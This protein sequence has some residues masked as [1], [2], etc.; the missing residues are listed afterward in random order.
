MGGLLEPPLARPLSLR[1][2]TRDELLGLLAL[3]ADVRD[4]PARYAQTRAGRTL[5]TIFEKPSLRTQVSFQ[6]AAYQLGAKVIDLVPRK[7]VCTSGNRSKT[8]RERST[9]WWTG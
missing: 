8:W 1:E 4:E 3:A 9:A 6:V 2:V 7:S 5:A